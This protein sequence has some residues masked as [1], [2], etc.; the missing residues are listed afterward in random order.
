M[1]FA[2]LALVMLPIAASDCVGNYNLCCALHVEPLQCRPITTTGRNGVDYTLRGRIVPLEDGS[3]ELDLHGTVDGERVVAK[4]RKA[5][6]TVAATP[7]EDYAETIEHTKRMLGSVLSGLADEMVDLMARENKSGKVA[8]SRAYREVF[9]PLAVAAIPT[10]DMVYGMQAA[11]A[12]GIPNVNYAKR[13]A[14]GRNAAPV[15]P[16][17][18]A[19]RYEV[20]E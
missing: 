2:G 10:D 8:L 3:W 6:S 7:D 14:E 17:A 16:A 19:S 15:A 20:V 12:K 13:V 5:S 4:R 9:Q 18:P 11:I 1:W